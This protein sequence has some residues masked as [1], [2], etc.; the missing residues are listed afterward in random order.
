MAKSRGRV[1]PVAKK[2]QDAL[3]A[4]LDNPD[5]KTKAM[6]VLGKHLVACII[7]EGRKDMARAGKSPRGK[8]VPNGGGLG[9]SFFKTVK[10]KLV[11]ESTIEVYSDWDWLETLLQG[12]PKT[13][14]TSLVADRNANLWRAG[15]KGKVRKTLPISD[16]RGGVLFRVAPLKLEDA[17][18]HP[19]IAKHTFW[20]RGRKR[21]RK[22]SPK[23]L[24]DFLKKNMK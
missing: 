19:G 3:F 16:G 5:L 17:W 24:A 11:G 12:M 18:V 1:G 8:P 6:H 22:E 9:E 21:W 14:M 15:K 2:L 4:K 23:I 13:K 10:Y 7:Y 20:D